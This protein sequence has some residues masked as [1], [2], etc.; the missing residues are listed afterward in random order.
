MRHPFR[1]LFVAAM[2]AMVLSSASVALAKSATWQRVD[3][4][5]HAEQTGSVMLVSGELPASTRL[6]AAAELAVPAG[7]DIQWIGE[8]LGGDSSADPTLKYTKTTG[9]GTDVYRFTLTKARTAQ[10]EILSPTAVPFDGTTYAPSV[11]WISSQDVPEVRLTVRI[12]LGAQVT[13]AASGAA[14]EAGPAGFS[15]Y[16]KSSTNV[17]AGDAL[18]LDF[19]YAAPLAAA[20]AAKAGSASSDPTT[21]LLVAIGALLIGAVGLL[22]YNVNKQRTRATAVAAGS[23]AG[24]GKAAAKK[25]GSLVRP[26]PAAARPVGDEPRKRRNLVP[27]LTIFAVVG[28]IV[29]GTLVAGAGGTSA[30]VVGG[31]LTKSFGTAAPCASASVAVVA[32]EG[33]DLA[34]QGEKLLEAFTGQEGVTDVT[35]DI[36]RSTIDVGYCESKQSPDS[37]SQLLTNTGL[38]SVAQISAASAEATVTQ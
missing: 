31:K 2:F 18:A 13:K 19:A 5:L 4:A 9:K 20:S 21:G 22:V 8:I 16:S 15:Y 24:S 12:P 6:P 36:E 35:L 30:K 28:A 17:K 34:K 32:N 7:S 33:V 23:S 11:A 25:G 1:T 10:I 27:A 29:A 26:M 38:V 3:V 37:I 14:V